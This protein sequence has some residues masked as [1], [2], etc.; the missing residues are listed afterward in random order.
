MDTSQSGALRASISL[1]IGLAAFSSGARA[2]TYVLKDLGALLSSDGLVE[3]P[4][5]RTWTWQAG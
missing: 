4:T 5:R 1:V 3:H 2:E